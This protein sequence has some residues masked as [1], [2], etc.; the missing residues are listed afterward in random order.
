MS[1]IPRIAPSFGLSGPILASGR[2]GNGLI[3]DTYDA[4]IEVDGSP[5]RF[6]FQKINHHVFRDPYGLMENVA[7]V[8]AHVRKRVA[9]EDPERCHR[10]ALTI[11]PT[12]DGKNCLHLSSNGTAD[13]AYWRCFHFIDGCSSFDV[14]ESP[15]LAYEAARKF[16]EFQRLVADLPGPRL[17]E[18]I[19]DFHHTPKRFH[20]FTAAI[21]ADSHGRAAGCRDEIGFA[22][23]REPI[24]HR[25]LALHEKG[26][27]PERITHNDTKIS[28]V[29]IDAASAQGLCV[30]DLD[31]VMP[32]LSLYDFGDMMRT[33]LSPA[34]EDEQDLS[35]I[36]VR[37]PVFEALA[38]GF[39]E[40]MSEVLTPTE[41]D[42]LAFSGKLLTYEVGLRFLTDHLQG[43][44]YFGAKFPDHN[45]IRARNQF[46]LV[47][48][49]EQ[50]EPAMN[51]LVKQMV[52][53]NAE[54]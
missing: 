3:N 13:E 31:T 49:L 15:E 53:A 29:L 24:A 30:V 9:A 16:G 19:P 22:L 20:A 36:K 4:T 27:I 51:Q 14:I 33:C 54:V 38:R 17:V 25:L 44:P 42:H 26:L 50:Q 47:Q 7:R 2:F 21:E 11:I 23:E 6:I 8:C 12:T 1:S 37:L 35:K 40:E 28:N 32:G 41:V 10:R 34:A 46:A 18:T 52:T 43:D 39:L 5:Q 48:A 45:L